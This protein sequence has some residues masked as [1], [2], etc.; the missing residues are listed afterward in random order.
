MRT[1]IWRTAIRIV[2]PG[3]RVAATVLFLFAAHLAQAQTQAQTWPD[4][5]LR[6]LIGFSAGGSTDVFA[7]IIQLSLT[8]S[9]GQSI[10][11]ENRPGA[12][13]T[14]AGALLAKAAPDGYTLMLGTSDIV[15][16]AHLISNLPYD[17]MKDFTPV[18]TLVI[19]PLTFVVHPS[20]P[21]TMQ[22]FVA[23]ARARPGQLSYASPGSGSPNHL[24]AEILMGLAGISMVH[25]PYKSGGQA[26]TDLASGHVQASMISS[27]QASPQSRASKV[28]VLAVAAAGG[29]RAPL[30]AQAPSFAEAGFPGF[31]PGFWIGLIAPSGTPAAI[32]Q[33]LNTEFTSAL[34]QPEVLARTGE[35]GME[36]VVSSSAEMANLIRSDYET[37]GSIIRERKIVAN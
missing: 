17:T 35:L 7:R 18:S 19:L 34:R 31:E 24:Y 15:A 8:K 37:L 23:Y 21:A 12:G 3:M 4:K 29:K 36:T 20:L 6:L 27:V 16:N 25:V 30:L 1:V 28:R 11:I 22:E 13:T 26:I 9:L 32:V 5:P 33:R 10:I 2:G 14:I